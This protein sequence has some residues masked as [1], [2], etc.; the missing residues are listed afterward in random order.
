ML[1]RLQE[2]QTRN[3]G[4]EQNNSVSF[5][6]PAYPCFEK[7]GA[8]VAARDA[9]PVVDHKV[10]SNS[11]LHGNASVLYSHPFCSA[12]S[13]DVPPSKIQTGSLAAQDP[14]E[15]CNNDMNQQEFERLK[16]TTSSASDFHSL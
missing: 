9:S 6:S 2:A 15:D 1:G 16:S 12:L 4:K 10:V 3:A 13:V 7:L 5:V 8:Q 11:G 14:P